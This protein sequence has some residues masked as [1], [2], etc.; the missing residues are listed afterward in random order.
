MSPAPTEEVLKEEP[1]T[2]ENTKSKTLP[3][4]GESSSLPY[5]L[6]GLFTAF[7]GIVLRKKGKKTN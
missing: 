7:I 3:K 1:K 4:T 2:T 6:V 5:Y